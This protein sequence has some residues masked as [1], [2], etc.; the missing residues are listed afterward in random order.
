[1][2]IQGRYITLSKSKHGSRLVESV[3][4]HC[5]VSQKEAIVS[6][7]LA[8]EEELSADFYGKFVLR[9]VNASHFKRKQ[10]V[11]QTQ[12][13]MAGKRRELFQ[14]IIGD[15]SGIQEEVCHFVTLH[16]SILTF[17]SHRTFL[18]VRRRSD[19]VINFT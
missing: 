10:N 4:R 17:N 19:L 8:S 16:L 3:W 12:Q 7:L 14:D 6:E 2:P 18:L 11:W 1:M 9:N 13:E 15:D 5:T